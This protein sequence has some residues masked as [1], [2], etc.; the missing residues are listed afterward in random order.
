MKFHHT[1]R[2]QSRRGHIHQLRDTDHLCLDGRTLR[3]IEVD[4]RGE[5]RRRSQRADA[6]FFAPNNFRDSTV[7]TPEAAR[8]D[9][10]AA[11]CFG[12]NLFSWI[13]PEGFL[14][15]FSVAHS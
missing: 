13:T 3:P 7:A 11:Q 4:D 10:R 2:H 14:N 15:G 5:R 1:D 9:Q 6:E 8:Y 12:T